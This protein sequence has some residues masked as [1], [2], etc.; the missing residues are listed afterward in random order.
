MLAHQNIDLVSYPLRTTEMWHPT[1]CAC[2]WSACGAA[3]RP[4]PQRQHGELSP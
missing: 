3:P 1:D 2:R 4:I